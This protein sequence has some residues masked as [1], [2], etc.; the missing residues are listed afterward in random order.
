MK[1][2]ITI[3]TLIAGLASP[4]MAADL[5]Y[6]NS[7]SAARTEVAPVRLPIFKGVVTVLDGR[8]VWYGTLGRGYKVRL[9]NVDACELPQWGYDPEW[10]DRDKTKSPMPVPCGPLAKAWLKRTI[11]NRVTECTTL[12]YGNDGIPLAQ[13]TVKG[14]DIAAEMLRVGWARVDSPY[15]SQRYLD[16]Q[17]DAMAARY[18]MWGTYVLDMNEWR[19]KAV[20]KTVN[21]RPMADFVLLAERRSEISPPFADARNKPKR[22]DR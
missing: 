10:S 13:C 16:L 4:A 20:D 12:V 7:Q 19:R 9:A 5:Q 2:T 14:R 3:A 22:I 1:K 15:A 6:W 11:G 8:T 21:R 18:G 17:T